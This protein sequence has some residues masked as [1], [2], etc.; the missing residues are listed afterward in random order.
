MSKTEPDDLYPRH[1]TDELEEA[2]ATSRVVNL[3]G[4]RQVGKTTLARDLFANAA[5]L[6]LDDAA[7]LDA[8]EADPDGQ[9]TAVRRQAGD[10]PVA[11][12]EVQR[13][14]RVALAI[15]A[16]VD[17]DR[18]KGQFI[19]TGSSN[20]FATADVAD[21][22]A[23]RM[24]TLKLWP[25][26]QAEAQR[27]DPPRL[28]D[29]ALGDAPLLDSLPPS[30]R[31]ERADYIDLILA[32]GFPDAFRLDL[33]PRQRLYRDYVDAVVDRDVADVLRIRKTDRL[34][35]LIEQ[36]AVRTA[37]EVNVSAL[38]RLIGLTRVT[39]DQYMDVLLRL[40]LVVRLGAWSS[41][42]SRR[43]IK[44]AK[45]HFVDTG[46]AAALRRLNATS[47]QPNADPTALG[48][49]AET[50]ALNELLRAAPTLAN[51]VKLFHWRDHDQREIDILADAGS[52]L[53]GIEVKASTRVGLADFSSLDWFAREG[54][55]R[56]RRM[57]KIVLSFG[58][59]NYSFGEGR[60][61]LPLS[62]LWADH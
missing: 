19:L 51:D 10:R 55:G 27:R 48:G 35:R 14:K 41:G 53:V 3:I 34:R 29:W 24:R 22:L 18:R 25:L 49:L 28:L 58:E 45:W 42:E 17:R 40:S 59:R 50:F 1:L 8:I 54:P 43:E 15:K 31:L 21:S 57:T 7:T 30:P 5:Y 16:I 61:G 39:I 4:P 26:T 11:I 2:V 38:S 56:R 32:G 33:R 9:L 37:G 52:R 60:F 36:T 46:V 23:G 62:A 44:N 47:F 6:T 20:V 13:S 12:D